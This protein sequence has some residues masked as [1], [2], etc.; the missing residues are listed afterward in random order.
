[1]FAPQ[2]PPP[3]Y[4]AR[5]G[6]ELLLRPGEAIANAEDML[7]LKPFVTAQAPRYGAIEA[8]TVIVSGDSDDVVSVDVHS[9]AIAAMLPRGRLIVLPG[10]GHMLHF[11]ATDRIAEAIAGLSTANSSRQ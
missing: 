3:D 1:V 11:A 7:A 5:A 2:P 10:V 4:I 9:R 6:S 8:P